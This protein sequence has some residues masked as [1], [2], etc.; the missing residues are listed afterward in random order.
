MNP[1]DSHSLIKSDMV[2][3]GVDVPL[4]QGIETHSSVSS[5]Q[6]DPVNPFWHSHL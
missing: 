3:A 5:S 6:L 1:N 2:P 4:R